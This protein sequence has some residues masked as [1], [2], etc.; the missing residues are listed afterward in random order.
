M[1]IVD[2][3]VTPVK[4]LSTSSPFQVSESVPMDINLL[5]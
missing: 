1:T 4:A 3:L 5:G 2:R